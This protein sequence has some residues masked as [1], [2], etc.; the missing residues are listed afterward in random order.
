M[1][2]AQ[3][4]L[5]IGGA[6][7]SGS[8]ILG[9][10]L[11]EVPGCVHVGEMHQLWRSV[12]PDNWPCEC[13]ALF[14]DCPFWQ[15]VMDRAFGGIDKVDCAAVREDSHAVKRHWGYGRLMRVLDMPRYRPPLARYAGTLRELVEALRE[16]S[17]CQIVV[18]S[19]KT[20]PQAAALQAAGYQVHA[21]HLVRHPAAV[22]YS[23][24]RRRSIRTANGEETTMRRLTVDE[25]VL[26]WNKDNMA[27]LNV[28]PSLTTCRL[29][30]YEDFA[31]APAK[32]LSSLHEQWPWLESPGE[33]LDEES[34]I[35]FG[36]AHAAR[37]NPVLGRK[38]AVQINLDEEWREQLTPSD[39]ESILKGTGPV[40][41]AL[42][43][44]FGPT[45]W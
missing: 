3:P 33:L 27:M 25:S 40:R 17:G 24:L 43:S 19:S 31:M 34:R 42:D 9:R 16:E 2:I 4:L 11:G 8:T 7:R 30:R 21:L 36:I 12:I 23:N 41:K 14:H 5:F 1:A 37:G 10:V 15:Q 26:R 20:A 39:Q 44:R 13:D 18:D 28:G 38:G 6:S 45:N 29:L 32:A 22:A 35:H